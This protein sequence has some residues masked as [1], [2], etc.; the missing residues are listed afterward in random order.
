LAGNVEEIEI[1]RGFISILSKPM[2]GPRSGK[3]KHGFKVARNK[4]LKE[5]TI[6]YLHNFCSLIAIAGRKITSKAIYAWI[7]GAEGIEFSLPKLLPR[8]KH[9]RGKVRAQKSKSHI[10]NRVS[11]H[12]RPENITQR[13]ELGHLEGDLVFNK[14]SQ[15]SNVLTIIDRKS[16]YVMLTKNESKR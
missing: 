14:G 12:N 8:A 16:R 7:Y 3:A 6:E 2:K 15:S 11:I 9:K 4:R 10:P 1:A 5:Y 13:D